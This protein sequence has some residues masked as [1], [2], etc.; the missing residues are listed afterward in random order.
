MRKKKVLFVLNANGGGASQGIY[1]YLEY[2]NKNDIE[3]YLVLPRHPSGERYAELK[4]FCEGI[5]VTKLVWW[6]IPLNKISLHSIF[7]FVKQKIKQPFNGAT[8]SIINYAKEQRIDCIY[9]SSILIKEGAEAAKFLGIPHFWHIKETF[10]SMGR[11]KFL[12]KDSALQDYVINNSDKIICM[13]NYISSFFSTG[14]NKIEIINDGVD[15]K[16]FFK[17]NNVQRSKDRKRLNLKKDEL[18]IGCIASLSASW[19]NHAIILH[20]IRMLKR[21]SKLK[22]I[23]MG[24]YQKNLKIQSIMNHLNIIQT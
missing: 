8:N 22:F 18:L 11:V 14:K 9:T 7:L 3:P 1:E 12:M 19:K 23:F 6:N 20:A 21:E 2:Q 24:P 15:F 13:T 17:K 10:G 5:L 4:S 16:K